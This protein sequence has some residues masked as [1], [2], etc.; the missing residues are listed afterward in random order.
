MR[1][2]A[3]GESEV[4]IHDEADTCYY[5]DAKKKLYADGLSRLTDGTR[6]KRNEVVDVRSKTST[7]LEY[8]DLATALS[9]G[10]KDCIRGKYEAKILGV[11]LFLPYSQKIMTTRYI[12][13]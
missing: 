13:R 5:F 9:E 4:K 12:L 10:G 8:L 7:E 2:G 3:G 1:T 11:G 6:S